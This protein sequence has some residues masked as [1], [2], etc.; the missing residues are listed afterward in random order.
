LT[1]PPVEAEDFMRKFGEG[2]GAV[3]AKAIAQEAAKYIDQAH[4]DPNSNGHK[5]GAKLPALAG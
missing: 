4:F 5:A 1:P 3:I 2:F